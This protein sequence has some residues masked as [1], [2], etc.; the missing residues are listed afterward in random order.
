MSLY[1]IIASGNHKYTYYLVV[2][3]LHNQNNNFVREILNRA[4]RRFNNKLFV[5]IQK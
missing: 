2:P 4:A 1:K 5:K 3:T